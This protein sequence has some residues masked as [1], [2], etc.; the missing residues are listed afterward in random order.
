MVATDGEKV[1]SFCIGFKVG[2]EGSNVGDIDGSKDLIKS[3]YNFFFLTW[4]DTK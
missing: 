1:G 3:N 2:L 4:C